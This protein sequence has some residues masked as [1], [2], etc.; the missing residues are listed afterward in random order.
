MITKS[1]LAVATGFDRATA[2]ASIERVRPGMTVI[3]TSA[4]SGEGMPQ[5]LDYL[6][7][8]RREKPPSSMTATPPTPQLAAAPV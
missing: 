7:A 3:E 4:R 6:E 8:C 1:D 5:W 2:A